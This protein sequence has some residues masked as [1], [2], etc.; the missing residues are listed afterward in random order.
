MSGSYT[1]RI[2]P[3]LFFIPSLVYLYNEL[4]SNDP[5]SMNE[6]KNLV[7]FEIKHPQA[8]ALFVHLFTQ[9]NFHIQPYPKII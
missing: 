3:S 2:L 8:R 4:G 7:T 6:F 1:I 9:T 5:I